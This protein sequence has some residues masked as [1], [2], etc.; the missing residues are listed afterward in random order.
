MFERGLHNLA[1]LLAR[2]ANA[3]PA[4]G[5]AGKSDLD[6][7]FRRFFPE[8]Q[9]H[10]PLDDAEQQLPV[11]SCQWPV[12]GLGAHLVSPMVGIPSEAGNLLLLRSEVGRLRSPRHFT[13]CSSKYFLLR[14]AQRKVNSMEAR[15]R[16]VSAGNSVHSSK[17]MMMSAP[18]P[19]CEIGRA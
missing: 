7:A 12:A 14:S 10:A 3:Q 13:F 19:I 4:D 1:S 6:G 16:P 8:S 11:L 5:V 18:R 9:V 17:A 15:V 2:L